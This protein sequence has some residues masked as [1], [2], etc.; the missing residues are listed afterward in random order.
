MKQDALESAVKEGEHASAVDLRLHPLVIVNISE[1]FTRTKHR[2]PQNP[3][4]IGILL[5]TQTGRV[6]EVFHSYEAVTSVKDGV[7]AIDADYVKTKADQMRQVPQFSAYDILGWYATGSEPTKAD[8][9]IHRQLVPFNESPVF[10][11]LN[12]AISLVARDLPIAMYESEVRI[13]GDTPTLIF[14][15]TTYKIETGEAERIAVD[16][17][18]HAAPVGGLEG[19]KLST[20]S[21]SLQNAVRM[22]SQRVRIMQK[23]VEDTDKGVTPPDH[24]LLAQI[25]SLTNQ[26]PTIDSQAFRDDFVTE[27]NDGVL[28]AYLTAITKTSSQINELVTKHNLAFDRQSMR[29]RRGMH[30][31]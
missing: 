3:R 24:A 14:A 27:F 2:M 28:L 4:A 31:F 19:T 22:L 5:G 9:A 29:S 26:L 15:R 8:L 23:Y 1:H 7:I 6:V 18:A 20:H 11:L 13:V 10:L 25:A 21:L 17:V 16:H 30:P 12:P